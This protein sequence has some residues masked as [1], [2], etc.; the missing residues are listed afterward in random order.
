M[1]EVLETEGRES[2]LPRREMEKGVERFQDGDIL[3]SSV[4]GGQII[5]LRQSFREWGIPKE[6]GR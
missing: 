2:C 3:D 5:R 6:G 1:C 4:A